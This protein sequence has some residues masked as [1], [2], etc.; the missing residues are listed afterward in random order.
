MPGIPDKRGKNM[1]R[2]PGRILKKIKIK[3]K[4]LKKIR[5]YM[6]KKEGS[7]SVARNERCRGKGTKRKQKT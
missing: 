5:R 1:E 2:S 4:G 3:T 6:G 7:E